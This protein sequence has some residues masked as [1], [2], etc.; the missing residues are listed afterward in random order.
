M[1]TMTSST[2]TTI[3]IGT[4]SPN[5]AEP[6]PAAPGARPGSRRWR[7][8]STRSRRT[9]KTGSATVL[10]EP[11]VAFFGGRESDARSA[12]A[13]RW[14]RT[15]LSHGH[16][17]D[18]GSARCRRGPRGSV[19]RCG[20]GTGGGPRWDAS[21]RHDDDFVGT[22][23]ERLLDSLAERGGHAAD[24]VDQVQRHVMQREPIHCRPDAPERSALVTT[25]IA[26]CSCAGRPCA[27]AT[28]AIA[29]RSR[30]PTATQ[31]DSMGDV[32]ITPPRTVPHGP[33][34]GF[35]PG[36]GPPAFDAISTPP[37]AHP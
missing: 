36:A 33:E 21:D 35:A 29:R 11:L 17:G 32:R 30:S 15:P 19:R 16:E 2:A 12:V 18:A 34:F 25:C 4:S 8:P 6:M 5:A 9:A 37:D 10:R 20:H 23:V 22:C 3:A 13:W 14:T 31:H 7:R 27:Y 26:M 24:V 1:T 28:A